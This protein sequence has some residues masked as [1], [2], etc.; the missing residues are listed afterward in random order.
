MLRRLVILFI[1]LLSAVTISTVA[2]GVADKVV[3]TCEDGHTWDLALVTEQATCTE[4]G[5]LTKTCKVCGETE[6]SVIDA[7]GH[8][9]VAVA[10]SAKEPSCEEDGY[11]GDKECLRSG[12]S[13]IEEG[14][15]IPADGHDYD[16]VVT[17]PTC[18]EDG[19]TTYTCDC[20]KSYIADEV[21]ALG[22]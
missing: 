15:V 3:P 11:T 19:Y 14:E 21:D 20:G 22:H 10:G 8:D 17:A 6:D 13:Y 9:L 16:K 5:K 4:E 18:E 7:L 2:I 1:V 12:C